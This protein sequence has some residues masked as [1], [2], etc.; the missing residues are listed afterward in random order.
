V[1]GDLA[2]AVTAGGATSQTDL[3][4]P[5]EPNGFYW[6][7]SGGKFVNGQTTNGISGANSSVV[8][9]HYND[10]AMYG[11]EGQAKW[12]KNL[13]M[14]SPGYA[15]MAGIAVTMLNGQAIVYDNNGL[16]NG[17]SGAYYNNAGGGPDGD[18]PGMWMAVS[19]SDNVK[20]GFA[21]YVKLTQRTTVDKIIGYF[22]GNGNRELPFDPANVYNRFRMNLWSNAGGM[23]P[24]GQGFTGDVFSS[25]TTAGTFTYEDTNVRRIVQ[26]G[27]GDP[28]YRLVYTLKNPI[29]L[30]AGEYWF[31]H[32][33]GVAAEATAGVASKATD[34]LAS[35]LR[36]ARPESTTKVT[37]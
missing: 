37:Q 14:T 5:A 27:A 29:T 13:G 7:A 30:E 36:V 28:L 2:L 33:L 16:E 9:K 3:G 35:G 4:V 8:F 21:G 6:V 25:D 26:S 31:G 15:G 17:T 19:M 10:P 34:K 22:D 11:S 32:D 1:Y 24:A 12:T 20:T 18:K 23:P